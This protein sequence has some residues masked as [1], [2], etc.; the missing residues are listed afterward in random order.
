MEFA[1]I[2]VILGTAVGVCIG[3]VL[4]ERYNRRA[5][6]EE[7]RDERHA[8]KDALRQASETHNALVTTQ[9]FQGELM[10]DL[11]QKVTFMVQGI[12]K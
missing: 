6:V 4:G 12:K 5:V 8:L 3:L 11:N 2:A 1:L 9:K 10:D 7:M